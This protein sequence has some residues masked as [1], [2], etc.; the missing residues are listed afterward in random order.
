[1]RKEARQFVEIAKQGNY[2]KIK[3]QMAV[4]AIK[5]CRSCHSDLRGE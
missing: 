5:G 4:F 3:K 1:M 2:K